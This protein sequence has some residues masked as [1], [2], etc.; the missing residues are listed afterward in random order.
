MPDLAKALGISDQQLRTQLR[1]GKSIADIAK[2]QGKSLDDVRASLKADATTALDKAVKNG[3]LTQKQ[4]DELASHLDEALSHLGD[5]RPKL[6][7]F[8]GGPRGGGPV[9]FMRPGG[10]VPGSEDAPDP[11]PT[12]SVFS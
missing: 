8:R 10:F 1:D 6:F 4:A 7:R 5:A 3:D 11:T 2:A 12:G 9:P